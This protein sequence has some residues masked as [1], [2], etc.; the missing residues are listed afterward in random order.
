VDDGDIA[1]TDSAGSF[2]YRSAA[3]IR[4]DDRLLVCAVEHIDGWFLPGGKVRFGE[5]SA[6][7]LARELHEE[8][9][10]EVTVT[11]DPL[12]IT[13][14]IRYAGGLAHQEVCFYYVVP[15]PDGVLPESVDDRDEHRFRWIRSEDL[16]DL[17]FLP[18]EI[19][20][21]VT[22]RTTGIRHLAFDRRPTSPRKR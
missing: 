18:P 8:L 13:E 19:A 22:G 6:T 12:L 7:A 15:W 5:N 1:W 9:G 17:R 4:A 3:V 11:G 2:K 14:G 20:G 10:I 16:T 21:F